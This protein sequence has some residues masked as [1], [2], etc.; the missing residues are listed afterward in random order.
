MST[1]NDLP[2][3]ERLL[4]LLEV[5]LERPQGVTLNELLSLGISRSTLFALLRHLK[6]LGYVAQGG[7]GRYL[8][9]P[10]LL[11]WRG[12]GHLTSELQIAFYQEATSL[13]ISETLGLALPLEQG[14]I[15]VAQLEP[16]NRL[17]SVFPPHYRFPPESAA[18]QVLS[19][20]AAPAI[21]EQGYARVESEGVL[22][23]AFP[24]CADGT[25]P[26]AALLLSAPL[27][28]WEERALASLLARLR[29]AAARLSYRL[30]AT[31]YAPWQIA[32]PASPLNGRAL[33]PE[34]VHA[35]LQAPWVARLACVRPDGTPHV[36]PV[37]HEWDGKGFYVVAWPGS[38]WAEYLQQNPRLSLSIDEPW[39]P[40]RRVLVR[41]QAHPVSS[42][43][44]PQ[45]LNGL[46]DRLRRRYLGPGGILPA[47]D[48]RPFRIL[49]ETLHGWQGL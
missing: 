46:L 14:A 5:L 48:V 8:A 1:T 16:P 39:P 31:H 28:R 11:A 43:E 26:Q 17:H 10:R 45:G 33:T 27:F 37:W 21:R 42:A 36:V 40:L 32:F 22:E 13:A 7:R 15:L 29:E 34:E 4:G 3:V 19:P 18:A 24:I 9:G 47:G 20:Q 25:T 23:I 2:P 38:L 41:G 12:R 30:G 6:E 44:I 35:F 49:P